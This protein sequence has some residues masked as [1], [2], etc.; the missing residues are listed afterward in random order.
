MSDHPVQAG[1]FRFYNQRAAERELRVALLSVQSMADLDGHARRL[2]DAFIE[3][4]PAREAIVG[5]GIASVMSPGSQRHTLVV[6]HVDKGGVVLDIPWLAGLKD[7]VR[8][9]IPAPLVPRAPRGLGGAV[10]NGASA[11]AMDKKVRRCK[12]CG[13]LPFADQFAEHRA[14]C[15]GMTYDYGARHGGAQF[16]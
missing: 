2:I 5:P 14:E 10:G 8:R 12:A 13:A 1:P 3:A 7:P 11:S 6:N 15:Q 4:S 9:M 16:E